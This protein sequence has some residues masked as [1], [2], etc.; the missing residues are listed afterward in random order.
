[1]SFGDYA[2][3]TKVFYFNHQAVP[4]PKDTIIETA[5]TE[6]GLPVNAKAVYE[7]QYIYP[8]RGDRGRVE[9]YKAEAKLMPEKYAMTKKQ[10]NELPIS[11]KQTL[12][13]GKR[14]LW[15]TIKN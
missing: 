7:I 8:I 4:Q 13:N 15:P 12:A 2:Y 10:L 11:A 14:Y 1:M 6:K 9:L 5:W 3:D